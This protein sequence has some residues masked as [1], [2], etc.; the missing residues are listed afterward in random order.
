MANAEG[1]LFLEAWLAFLGAHSRAVSLVSAELEKACGISLAWFDVLFQVN[2][3]PER[4]LRMHE[5]A[6]VLLLSKSGLTRL[7]DRIEEAGLVERV[8]VPGDRRSLH[9][10][11]TRDGRQ[12]LR[13]A[14]VVTRRSIE[15][16]F[17]SRLRDSELR[18]LR[19][20]LPRVAPISRKTGKHANPLAKGSNLQTEITGWTRR[21]EEGS[22]ARIKVG[23]SR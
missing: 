16:H 19:D 5:L 10:Q 2:I 21:P 6:D 7:I 22:A 13:K 9:V 23:S 3:A 15:E 1:P 20:S 11:L 4:R 8:A 18:L 12:V 14:T 17:G